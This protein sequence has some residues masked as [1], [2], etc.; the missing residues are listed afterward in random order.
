MEYIPRQPLP[1]RRGLAQPPV[2]RTG[3]AGWEQVLVL[4]RFQH[5]GRF[6]CRAFALNRWN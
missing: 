2:D 3:I 1:L 5:I 6:D 4:D